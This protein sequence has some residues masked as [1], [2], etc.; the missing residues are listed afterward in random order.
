MRHD[1]LISPSTTD[2]RKPRCRGGYTL[3]FFALMTFVLLGFA[4]LLIDLGFAR[5]THRQM[6]TAVDS[7]ALEGLRWQND[8]PALGIDPRQ[9]ASNMVAEV[10]SSDLNPTDPDPMNFGAGPVVTFSG[11]SQGLVPG[12]TIVIPGVWPVPPPPGYPVY[13][14]VQ[15]NGTPGLELNNGNQTNGDLVTGVYSGNSAY[16]SA[17]GGTTTVDEDANYDRR[18][19][20]P[21]TSGT[22]AFLARMRRTDSGGIVGSLDD[23]AGV[24]SSSSPLPW[25]FGWGTM[26]QVNSGT[27]TRPQWQGITVRGTAIAAAGMVTGL[28]QN[29]YTVGLAKTVGRSYVIAAGSGTGA[30]GTIPGVAPFALSNS[31]WAAFSSTPSLTATLSVSFAT[32]SVALL[33]SAGGTVGMALSTTPD[34]LNIVPNVANVPHVAAPT[35]A[36]GEPLGLLV[37]DPNQSVGF[38]QS[39][40]IQDAPS[41]SVSIVAEYVPIYADASIGGQSWTI[42]GFGCLP[43]SQWTYTAATSASQATLSITSTNSGSSSPWPAAHIAGQNA[44]G[45]IGLPLPAALGQSGVITLF[46]AHS[47]LA[48]PLYAPVLVDHYI[49]PH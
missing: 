43:A 49:G 30:G 25:L 32:S 2:R 41:G 33:N 18:D 27:G 13:K 24:S 22:T 34:T 45:V 8:G 6:Q 37:P 28:S 3:V 16:V 42:I 1:E 15:S 48:N 9:Q 11:S 35:T 14:P 40:F 38:D 10:F 7:A 31:T 20:S 36:I 4:A 47:G 23:T 17:A 46:Q 21:T 44:S 19:F 39:A 5:L 29:P 12:P 26:M